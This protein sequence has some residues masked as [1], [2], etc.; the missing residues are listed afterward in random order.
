MQVD[1]KGNNDATS[2]VESASQAAEKAEA[3]E[4]DGKPGEAPGKTVKFDGESDKKEAVAPDMDTLYPVF[5]TIQ[6]DF[7]MP[8]RLFTD[9]NFEEFKRG[10]SLT[11]QKFQSVHDEQQ[12]HGTSKA[13]DESKR[14]AKRKRLEGEGELSTNFNPKYLTSRDLF[15]LEVW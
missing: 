9:S 2:G 12:S 11:L 14:S 10:L 7:S 3:T 5:W 15:D 6:A 8:T 1:S 13:P 4:T